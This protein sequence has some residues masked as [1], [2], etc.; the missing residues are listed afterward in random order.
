MKTRYARRALD[1]LDRIFGYLDERSP[2]G[3]KN[4]KRAIRRRQGN[5]SKRQ[6]LLA[7]ALP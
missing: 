4:V 2:A 3:A 6:G 1:D 5:R 7:R